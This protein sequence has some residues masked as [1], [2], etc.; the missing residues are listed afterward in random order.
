MQSSAHTSVQPELQPPDFS[1]EATP[2]HEH[3]IE[4]NYHLRSDPVAIPSGA[5]NDDMLD[6]MRQCRNVRASLRLNLVSWTT[7]D[8]VNTRVQEGPEGIQYR[9]V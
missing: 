9:H 6:R 4:A 2:H 3:T 8:L 1:K 5:Q 7:T